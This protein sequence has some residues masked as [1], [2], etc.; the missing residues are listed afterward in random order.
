MEFTPPGFNEEDFLVD[1]EE[2]GDNITAV[3]AAECNVAPKQKTSNN[4][5]LLYS[6]VVPD[7]SGLL[8][9]FWSQ[10]KLFVL[11]GVQELA[12]LKPTKPSTPE[13]P[14]HTKMQTHHF[15]L[16]IYRRTIHALQRE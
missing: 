8:C 7:T 4:M 9:S 3:G 1:G 14:A 10:N 13:T 2:P 6:T 5:K 15:H 16:L 12:E 11:D